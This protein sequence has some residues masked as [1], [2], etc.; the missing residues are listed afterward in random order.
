[1]DDQ[2][3]PAPERLTIDLTAVTDTDQLHATLRRALRFPGWTGRSWDA[4]HDVITDI[5]EL[6]KEIT[7][8]GWR[9]LEERLPDDAAA[10]RQILDR[11][12]REHRDLPSRSRFHYLP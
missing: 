9:Q 10:L 7:F 12:E 5:I 11:Y 3:T 1:M 2:E 8:I 4:F 6:P